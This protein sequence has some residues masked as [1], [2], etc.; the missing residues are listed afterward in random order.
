MKG[1]RQRRKKRPQANRKRREPFVSRYKSV[2]TAAAAALVA[3]SVLFCL[4]LAGWFMYGEL[5]DT[6][7]LKVR[8]INI[9][10]IKRVSEDEILELAG[11]YRGENI[12]RIRK[13]RAEASIKTHP[14]VEEARVTKVLPD[15]VDI[16]VAE[17]RPLVLVNIKGLFVMDENGVI[18]KRYSPDDRLDIPVV[19]GLDRL[20]GDWKSTFGPALMALIDVLR[21]GRRYNLDNISEI[22]ADPTYGFSVVTLNEGIRLELGRQRFREKF[23]D[24]E[25]VIEARDGNLDGIESIDL[26][27]DRGVIVRFATAGVKE[28][29][30][31]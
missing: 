21:Q 20:G 3:V 26:N 7:H 1:T 6:P 13:G 25:K 29:G 31:T 24:L 4:A 22:H 5:L 30:I 12:L 23:S 28:G 18:F 10:G 2:F 27:N 11:I 9:T 19:T 8:T 14:Y 17:R 15:T 16:W